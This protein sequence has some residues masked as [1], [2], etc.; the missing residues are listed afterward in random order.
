MQNESQ[1]ASILLAALNYLTPLVCMTV[2]I[3]VA[4]RRTPPLSEEMYKDFATKLDLSALRDD[5]AAKLESLHVDME[6]KFRELFSRQHLDGKSVEDKFQAIV[7][8]L[9]RI[10]GQL[11]RCPLFCPPVSPPQHSAPAHQTKEG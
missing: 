9:G 10:E 3:V 8:S 11:E 6:E 5:T 4:R 7:R 1:A 2:A